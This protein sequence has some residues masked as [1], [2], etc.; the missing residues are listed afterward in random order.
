VTEEQAGER[1]AFDRALEIGIV[2]A[3]LLA[4]ITTALNASSVEGRMKNRA[5]MRLGLV[6]LVSYALVCLRDLRHPGAA[7]SRHRARTDVISVL[8]TIVT[9]ALSWQ[10]RVITNDPTVSA[11]YASVVNA[12]L[13]LQ[14]GDRELAISLASVLGSY[15]AA[16]SSRSA[17]DA[18]EWLQGQRVAGAV[19]ILQG[20]S[21]ARSFIRIVRDQIDAFDVARATASRE[22]ARAQAERERQHQFGIL[23]DSALQILE[24][25][26]GRWNIDAETL[27]R[28]TD[29]E[30]GRLVRLL[31]GGTEPAE[32]LERGLHDLAE[33]YAVAGLDVV[34]T[35]EPGLVADDAVVAAL[36]D[37][38]REAL[39]NVL[40]HADVTAANVAAEWADPGIEVVVWDR[41]RGFDTD[42]SPK[43]FGL[44]HSIRD[45]M[46]DVRGRAVIESHPGAGTRVALWGPA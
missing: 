22:A 45:R 38:A 17:V 34:L 7:L 39:Q 42:R 28:R 20:S 10:E 4:A 25:I 31:E 5:A 40:K 33:T 29:Y 32:T 46:T 18:G 1:L 9:E 30:I 26:G 35:V 12:W 24:A 43:G 41:G 14:V 21:V 6:G 2:S 37:A 15:F 16:T 23:H 3:R 11:S 44:A 13:P 36:R 19:G 27:E 8:A